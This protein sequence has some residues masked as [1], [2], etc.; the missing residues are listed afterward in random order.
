[1]KR[2][3]KS[4]RWS[5]QQFIVIRHTSSE[6]RPPH[7]AEG[8]ER[9]RVLPPVAGNSWLD[10]SGCS[11]ELRHPSIRARQRR[12]DSSPAQ[13]TIR[14]GGRHHLPDGLSGDQGSSRAH[15]PTWRPGTTVIS[16][17]RR[18]YAAV[19]APAGVAAACRASKGVWSRHI[20]KRI[21]A[22]RRARATVAMRRPRRLASCSA[23]ARKPAP[24]ARRDRSAAQA[25]C[26]NNQRIRGL[27]AL[28]MWPRRW[29][30]AE[31]CSLGTKPR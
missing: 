23:H 6:R 27:P 3:V 16:E 31:L 30:S 12:C 2:R 24:S 9:E 1:M 20:A 8:G 11:R 18:P 5:Q 29:R 4:P 25:A 19:V 13:E 7:P 10:A 22:K 15:P 14:N 17:P 21:P 28:V 26:T